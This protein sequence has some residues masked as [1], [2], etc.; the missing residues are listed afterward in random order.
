MTK[1]TSKTKQQFYKSVVNKMD[2][3]LTM[4]KWLYKIYI[5]RLL[6]YKVLTSKINSTLTLIKKIISI[7]SIFMIFFPKNLRFFKKNKLL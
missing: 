2:Q 3:K 7:G 4:Y 6:Y 5:K 1:M